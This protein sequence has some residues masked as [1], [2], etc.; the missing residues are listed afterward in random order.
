MEVSLDTVAGEDVVMDTDPRETVVL[1]TATG[2]NAVVKRICNNAVAEFCY[3]LIVEDKAA[4]VDTVSAV[5]VTTNIG[6]C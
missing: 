2:K 6:R 3:N 4:L 5:E 1:E